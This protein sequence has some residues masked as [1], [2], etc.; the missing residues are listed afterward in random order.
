MFKILN[1]HI[2]NF[3][4]LGSKLYTQT[5]LN[6]ELSRYK[7]CNARFKT[8]NYHIINFVLVGSKLYTQNL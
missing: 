6:F 4:P 2:I 8:L 1:Y 3:I 7:L 5:L